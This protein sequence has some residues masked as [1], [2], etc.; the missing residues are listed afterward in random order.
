MRKAE[1]IAGLGGI[2]LLVSLF[3]QWY[4]L[5]VGELPEEFGGGFVSF[6]S[7]TISAW[8]AFAIIDV[9]LALI[10]LIAIAVPLVSA[11]TRGPAKSIGTAL[12]ASTLTPLAI[13]LVA[14]RIIFP[15]GGEDSIAIEQI[16][17]EISLGPALGAWLGLAGALIA[18]AGAWLSLRDESTP[19]AAPPDLPRRPAPPPGEA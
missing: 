18:F 4:E 13:L 11:F 3:L 17:V 7:E 12:I 9:L 15:P 10:A 19:G 6:E 2:L 8:D 16:R 14:F 1:P 5:G